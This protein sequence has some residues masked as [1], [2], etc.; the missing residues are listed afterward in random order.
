M[1]RERMKLGI[2]FVPHFT[3]EKLG[4]LGRKVENAGFDHIWVCDH[5]RNR[6][7]HSVLTH[8]AQATDKVK[9]GP[10]VTNP[11][12]IHPA[13]TATALT[14]LDEFSGG[15]AALGISAGDPFLLESIGLEHDRPITAVREAIQIIEGLWKGEK[16]EFSGDKFLLNGARLNYTASGDIP[17]Y[18]GG[19]RRQML[20]L[21]GSRADGAIINATHPDEVRECMEYIKDGVEKSGRKLEELEIVSH[22]AASIDEDEDKAK[23]KA[24]TATAFIASSAPQSTLEREGIS[25]ERIEKIRKFIG[26]N[27]IDRARD[28]ISERMIEVFSVSGKIEKL[29]NRIEELEEIGLEQVVIGSP[30]GLQPKRVIEE[31]G[32]LFS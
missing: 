30:I 9:I 31:I 28:Q 22:T 18:V 6:F 16:T 4:K 14:T 11:Y 17:V 3:L 29:E 5:Y 21:A 12:T 27:R 26:R 23:N 7:V 19:R 32:K 24:K 13:V 8:L 2:E 15:R 1:R 25:T 20:E 10:S